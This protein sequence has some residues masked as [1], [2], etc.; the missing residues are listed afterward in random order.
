MKKFVVGA[1]PAPVSAEVVTR[2]AGVETATVG[3]VRHWGFMDSGLVPMGA[4]R[5]IVATAVTLALP[6]QDSTM[7]HHALGLV[8]PGHIL[9]VDRLGDR[10]HACWGGGVTRAAM[11]A[12]AEG[13]IVDGVCTDPHEIRE[14]G[15]ALWSRGVSPLTT[16]VYGLGGLLNR[17]V[18][19]GGVVVNP[20]DVLLCDEN[21]ILVLAPDEVAEVAD[22]A[23]ARQARGQATMDKLLAGAKLGDLS[24]ATEMVLRDGA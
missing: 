21:G 23:L 8:Q 3:H 6:A 9:V 10:T 1:M 22:F 24:G 16:R 4:T 18:C 15:F 7:L 14:A 2:L 11:A 19:C 5:R 12:G 20:G 13:A 17:P